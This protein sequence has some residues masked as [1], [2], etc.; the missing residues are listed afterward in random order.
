MITGGLLII[1]INITSPIIHTKIIF[2]INDS[3]DILHISLLGKLL[4]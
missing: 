1:I 4:Q 3:S 2:T